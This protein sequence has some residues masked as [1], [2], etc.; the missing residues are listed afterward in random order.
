MNMSKPQYRSITVF[1][2][3]A[4]VQFDIYHLY[5]C[6]KGGSRIY[7]NTAYIPNYKISVFMN[8]IFR[9]I[10]ENRNLDFIEESDD[11]DEFQNKSE[12][13]FVDLKKRV[14]MECAFS[15]KFKRWIPYRIAA[16]HSKIVHVSML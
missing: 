6:G 4:D 12:D 14:A 3:S 10:K 13:R 7:Y 11:E 16:K 15:S 8:S 2:V 9:D 5:M 1:E